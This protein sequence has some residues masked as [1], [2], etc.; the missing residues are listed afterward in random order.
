MKNKNNQF[1]LKNLVLVSLVL[2]TLIALS[3]F[4]S[5]DVNATVCCEKTTSGLF[6]QDVPSSQCASNAR[7]VPTS[8]DSTSYC[9]TGTCY[10]SKEGTC[11]DNTPQLVCNANNGT[12]SS[13]S[14]AA[15]GLGCC[16]LGD[17]AAFVTLVRCK[18]LSSFLGLQTNFN[19]GIKDEVSCVL[20][21][22]NQDKG[23]CVYVSE[24]ERTCKMTTRAECSG[25]TG[26]G[27]NGTKGEFHT[28]KL[29]TAEEFGTNCAP[30]QQTKCVPGKDGVYF[31]DSCGNFANIYDSSKV[32]DSDYW[33]NMKDSSES[34]GANSANGNSKS[35]GNCNYL[36]GSVCRDSKTAGVSSATYGT[37][38]C[39]DLNCKN[40]QNGKS[41]KHG[42][43]WC[44]YNDKGEIDKANNAVGSGFFKHICISGEEVVETCADYRN[45]ICVED[46]IKTTLGD[47][48]QAGCRVNRWA[49]CISQNNKK[50]CENTDRRD[51]LWKPGASI[52][53][54]NK[55]AS[56]ENGACVPL[57]SPGIQFWDG[58]SAKTIC[59]QGNAQCVVGFEKG[60]FGNEKCK[61][62]CECLDSGWVK[63]KSEICMALGDCGPKINWVGSAGYDNGYKITKGKMKSAE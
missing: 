55:T 33:T 22:Q 61:S 44:V 42:E 28:G 7:Q 59:A 62:N 57:N 50:D 23:A 39:A 37:N 46:K 2:V 63:K 12:W 11:T 41:Y 53:G 20:S 51:C 45:E 43:S 25:I 34:C 16:V 14:P 3:N 13:E 36:L 40:T 4:V 48:S 1:I 19:S 8:C 30:T 35:C 38:I 31:V 56:A 10:D 6:C 17:Q 49:D 29:C 24:F 26:V 15:C 47:F 60:L 58:D 9:K 54:V 21:V 32:K 52:S 5:A 27:T 18:R